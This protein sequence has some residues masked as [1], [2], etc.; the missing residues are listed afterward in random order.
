MSHLVSSCPHLV[1]LMGGIP[2]SCLVFTGSMV[3]TI[4]ETCFRQHFEPWGQDRLRSCQWLQLRAANGLS[5]PYIGYIELD[6][7]LCGHVVS[8][9]GVLVVRDP[10]GGICT[11]VPG[12]LDGVVLFEPPEAGL[13]AVL[14][15]SPSLVRV[16]K[17]TVYLPVVNVGM[18]DVFLYSNIVLGMLNDVC[19]VS[20][21]E[22]VTE[23]KSV[24]ASVN[25]HSLTAVPAVSE[26]IEAV[27]LSTL[28]ETEQGQ[29]LEASV[30]RESSSPYASPIV[31]VKKKDGSLRM[32]VNYRQL[33]AKTRKDAFPLPR[34]E[35]SLDA[36]T[37]A[38]WFST[39]D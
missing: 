34:I 37:G 12:V 25:S 5:I 3:S 9:C 8:R 28:T 31:L 29:L 14:L 17:G 21:P 16:I 13:P 23:V 10:P 1:V 35:E 39:L 38:C 6:I 19:V 30:I 32:C 27:D 26:P 36:M 20:L 33:N 4:T 7:K 11:Q 24:A 2:V 15:A 22:G 18:V